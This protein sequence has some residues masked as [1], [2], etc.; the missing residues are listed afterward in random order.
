MPIYSIPAPDG[1]TYSIEGPAG[2]TRDQIIAAILARNPDAAAAAP[3]QKPT[4]GVMSALGSS[5]RAGVGEAAAGAGEFTGLQGLAEFGKR[6]Q[7]QAAKT[8][9]PTSDT[10]VEAADK[11]GLIAGLGARTSQFLEP[12]AQ[13]AGSM[14]GRFGAP[15]A[16][17]AA[18][19]AALPEAV[20]AAPFLGGALEVAGAGTIGAAVGLGATAAAD[21]PIEI[22]QKTLERKAAGLPANPLADITYGLAATAINSFSGAALTGPIKGLLGKTAV[23]EARLIA[24]KVLSG[25]LTSAEAG[26]QLSST[27]RNVLHST[28]ENAVVG[29]GMMVGNEALSRMAT[30]Q[31]LT[32]PEA[33]AKYEEATKGAVALAPMFGL[34]HGMK[35][36]GA[37]EDV[38]QGAADTRMQA[39]RQ[40]E[41]AA[42]KLTE[43][44]KQSPDYAIKAQA[45]YQATQKEYDDLKAQIIKSPK[46]EIDKLHNSDI[47]DKLKAMEPT[48][49]QTAE[50]HFNTRQFLPAPPPEPIGKDTTQLQQADL[51]GNL[52]TPETPELDMQGKPVQRTAPEAQAENMGDPRQ[53]VRMLEQLVTQY[54]DQARTASPQEILA[55]QPKYE[56][57][58]SALEAS[59]KAVEAL[60]QPIEEQLPKLQKQLA[61]AQENGD[62]TKAAKLSQQ[63]LDLQA[64]ATPNT[65]QQMEMQPFKSTVTGDRQLAIRPKYAENLNLGAEEQEADIAA[66][67]AQA[68]AQYQAKGTEQERQIKIAPEVR[69]LQRI[70]ERPAGAVSTSPQFEMFGTEPETGASAALNQVKKGLTSGEE[71]PTAEEEKTKKPVQRGGPAPFNLYARQEGTAEP[72]TAESLRQRIYDLQS[73]DDLSDEARAFLRRAAANVSDKDTTIGT[74]ASLF[75][76]LDEQLGKIE[77]AEEGVH[78][79]G[80]PTKPLEVTPRGGEGEGAMAQAL[81]EAGATKPSSVTAPA[82]SVTTPT[83]AERVV[84]TFNGKKYDLSSS[85]AAQALAKAKRAKYEEGVAAGLS[86]A[87]AARRANLVT[88]EEAVQGV[89]TGAG[90]TA[91]NVQGRAEPTLRTL[92]GPSTY[93][94]PLSMPDA[95]EQHLRVKEELAQEE[96]KQLPL[97]KEE[98][99]PSKALVRATPA[100][101]QRFLASKTV[102]E[103]REREKE[104]KDE[105][106]PLKEANKVQASIAELQQQLKELTTRYEITQV[107]KNIVTSN[108][109]ADAAIAQYGKMQADPYFGAVLQLDA[110]S[111]SEEH[112][113]LEAD[114]AALTKMVADLPK[115]IKT[116]Q[117]AIDKATAKA[118]TPSEAL[119]ENRVKIEILTRQQKVLTDALGKLEGLQATAASVK[120]AK[121]HIDSMLHVIAAKRALDNLR[122]K[123]ISREQVVNAQTELHDAV[124]A[125]RAA[126]ANSKAKDEMRDV[127][128]RSYATA[129]KRQELSEQRTKAWNVLSGLPTTRYRRLTPEERGIIETISPGE[130]TQALAYERHLAKMQVSEL[131]MELGRLDKESRELETKITA[132]KA[133]SESFLTPGEELAMYGE[134]GSIFTKPAFVGVEGFIKKQAELADKRDALETELNR[135][136]AAMTPISTG[137]RGEQAPREIA[138]TRAAEQAEIDRVVEANNA[139]DSARD[140][141]EKL[142]ASYKAAV[143]AGDAKAARAFVKEVAVARADLA[144]ARKEIGISQRRY[145]AQRKVAGEP[146]KLRTGTAESKA[147]AGVT[148][149]TITEQ[150]VEPKVSTG[151]IIKSANEMAAEKIAAGKALTKKEVKE[152]TLKQQQA[153]QTAAFDRVQTTTSQVADAQI[154]VDALKQAQADYAAKRREKFNLDTLTKAQEDL[155]AAQ[156]A[157]Q[158]AREQAGMLEDVGA[159]SKTEQAAEEVPKV[160]ESDISGAVGPAVFRTITREGA[161]MKEQNI[162]EIVNN[163]TKNWAKTPD[164]KIVE[165]EAGLPDH[166]QEQVREARAEYERTRKD[167]NEQFAFPGV[168]DP[169]TGKV[170][171]VAEHLYNANDVALTIAHEIAGHFG[172]REMLGKDYGSVMDNIYEGNKSIQAIADAKMKE[173]TKLTRQIAVEEALADIAEKGPKGDKGLMGALRKAYY[174]VKQMLARIAGI[175]NVSDYE[176]NQIVANARRYVQEG[177]GGRGGETAASQAVNR[178]AKY[179]PELREA[180]ELAE[181]VVATDRSLKEKLK[182]QALGTA[183]LEL[184]VKGVDQFAPVTRHAKQM[185]ELTGNQMMYYLRMSAQR[186]NLLG[187]AV[188]RGFP[189]L[190]KIVREDGRNEFLYE[191]QDNGRSLA[192]VAKELEPANKLTGSPDAT[193][194]LFSLYEIAKRADD[195]G[196]NKLNYGGEITQ[197]MLNIAMQ[198][199]KAVPGLEA[200]FDR[201]KNEYHEYNKDGIRFAISSGAISKELGQKML[202]NKDYVPYYREGKD[203]AVSL[204]MGNEEITKVGNVKDQPYLHELVGGDQRIKDFLNSSVQNSNMLLDMGLRN[205]A[206][207]TVAHNLQE[208]G[209]AKIGRG[210]GPATNNV[211][212]FKV[213]GKDMHA[214]VQDTPEV[215]ADLLVKGMAGIPVQTSALLRMVG[216]PSRM[217]RTAFVANPVSAARILFKDTISSAMVGGSGFDGIRAA[218]KNVKS[219]LM[220]RRGISGGEVYTGTQADL[221]NILRKVQAGGPKWEQWLA[222][223]NALH[224]KADAM[225]RQIRYESYRKQGLSEMESTLQSLESMNFTR[226]GIS[227]SLHVLSA[228]NPFLNSQIQGVNTLVKALRGNMPMNEKLKIQQ[229]IFQR[230]MLMAGATMLYTAIMQDDETYKNATPE[231]KYNNFFVDFPGVDEK[232]R[233]PIPF[234]AGILFK[235]VPEALMNYMYGHDKEAATAMRM[236]AIKMVPGADTEY[237]PQILKPALEAQLGKSL[238]TGRDIESRHEQSLLPEKRIRDTTS[239]LAVELGST[240]GVSPVMVDHLIGGYTGMMGL[241]V[242]KMASSIVFG[243]INPNAP[244]KTLSQEPIVGSLFQPKDAGNIVEEAYQ[245]MTKAQEVKATYDD[246]LK[247]KHRPEEAVEFLNKHAN[248]FVKA[249]LATAFTSQMKT[250]QTML[251]AVVNSPVLTPEQKRERVEK[252]KEMRTRAAERTLEMAH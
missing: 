49:R 195:V 31:D 162:A 192:K 191:T 19:A 91:V 246:L 101:F 42:N 193:V 71:L 106:E 178:V 175:K 18:A 127:R 223:G 149:Q 188:G 210:D 239:G 24:P 29:T 170:F 6:Q 236:L 10:D 243:E 114:I 222:K 16:A 242:A 54:Q 248:D 132:A 235:A 189:E 9:T 164:V 1:R 39:I 138:T 104:I 45:L 23:D 121:D 154:R 206:T 194:N 184:E 7:E 205:R 204:Y 140:R 120:A 79:E 25:E 92:R 99:L 108:A 157:N 52:P 186:L 64:Q 168:Y 142:K 74:N 62:V 35:V 251:Q 221:A 55:I 181:R 141:I 61:K 87:E 32:S 208:I 119:K 216:M 67:Q 232:V 17:G 14:L 144:D 234:E 107:A 244:E 218:L 68:E 4:S 125:R 112:A 220:E 165:T 213:D 174:A 96:G 89:M 118:G 95:L 203:G 105:T 226:R 202:N 212:R 240:F 44:Q 51:F 131:K 93:A 161:G 122:G 46:A 69:A 3:Q 75:T 150:R 241:A 173:N 26:K 33:M 34:Y 231:Q 200:A 117:T 190:R 48:L 66:Q 155:A 180:G 77:R 137:A 27:V 160:K 59:R 159:V 227:P 153:L 2:A 238:Y 250:Y 147:I 11:R 146:G 177:K 252:I 73:R 247:N 229:K 163:I 36:K 182:D 128:D 57:A 129:R 185:D 130:V 20:A 156:K 224:A 158:I 90:P 80:A 94:K 30:G 176:V 13:G 233:V 237:L 72:V 15:I 86:K 167:P 116:T 115:Q 5:F 136:E 40:A 65:Q 98:E 169:V 81:R 148:K 207:W 126:E 76:M 56:Q 83:A 37:A 143:E 199:I 38:L 145:A 97:F 225:T 171:L 103:L 198:R 82:T 179:S 43:Q 28:A 152:L 245:A 85:E 217:I 102:Q 21:A 123:E 249:P 187:E 166:L 172:L 50:D 41:E 109:Q 230:G 84:G 12:Y 228:M 201:A 197:D 47:E 60:P 63:I 88:Q 53:Q 215:P 214:V 100:T 110:A 151:E 113:R 58:R 183:A 22:G 139:A 133:K 8:Y 219:D 111:K 135:K 211:I 134:K 196:L 124:L 70:G 209:L 78:G